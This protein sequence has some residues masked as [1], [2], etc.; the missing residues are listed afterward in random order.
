MSRSR[1]P[2][3]KLP[4][5]RE[6]SPEK[7]NTMETLEA[8]KLENKVLTLKLNLLQKKC[9]DSE[10]QKGLIFATHGFYTMS[11]LRTAFSNIHDPLNVSDHILM[12]LERAM[13]KIDTKVRA[14]E[15]V[16]LATSY[17]PPPL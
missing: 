8:L 2:R 13:N 3:R 7:E 9:N 17:D 6:I 5:P 14:R 10:L 1:S 16:R 15:I 12:Q 4:S 11:D